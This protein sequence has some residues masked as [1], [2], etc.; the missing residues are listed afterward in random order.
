MFIKIGF[1]IS[2]EVWAYT[3]MILMLQVHT[4]READLQ[5]PETFVINPQV[6]LDFFLDVFGNRCVRFVAPPGLVR[7]TLDAVVRDSGQPDPYRPDAMQTPV[8]LLPYDVLPYLMSS[9]YCEVDKLTDTAWRL[10]GNTP[11]G[12]PRVQAIVDWVHNHITF[13]YHF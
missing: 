1:D 5:A 11:L 10:F 7:V 9:R 4:S 8:E 6:P 12:W 3:P 2:Y 13:G